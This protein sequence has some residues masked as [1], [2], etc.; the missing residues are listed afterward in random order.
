MRFLCQ[1][2]QAVPT[3]KSYGDMTDNDKKIGQK[4]PKRDAWGL[5]RVNSP[6]RLLW[7]ARF[8]S[9]IGSAMGGT[10]LIIYTAVTTNNP[11]S[12][13][14]LMLVTDFAPTLLSPLSGALSDR[15]ERKKVMI[16][17]EFLRGISL[18][19]LAFFSLTTPLL[20]LLVALNSIIGQGFDAASRS[21]VPSLVENDDLESANAALGLGTNGLDLIGPV[22]T[23]ILLPFFGVQGLLFLDAI[24]YFIAV[25][26][27]LGLPKSPGRIETEEDEK[28]SF[29][30]H[31]K[32]GLK[33]VWLNPAVRIIT[34]GFCSVVFF[35]AIDDVALVFLAKDSLHSSESEAVLLYAGAGIGLL[36]GFTL[37][38]RF[39][40]RIPFLTMLVLGYFVSSSGNILTGLAWAI[41]I[42]LG[43]QIIRGMGISM[44]DLANNTLIQ[45]FVPSH[46]LGRV[47]G[48][49]YGAV[50]LAASCSYLLGGIL[51]QF[52]NAR[53]VFIIAGGGGLVSA[54]FVALV[55]P[56]VLRRIQ[57]EAAATNRKMC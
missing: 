55:L 40:N 14:L 13:A 6:F 17:C 56:K 37:L 31:A 18:T 8:I 57:A 39:G 7:A 5:L 12:V 49:V 19:I 16:I 48:N 33:F 44:S 3:H 9:V 35:N 4:E 50:G 21:I 11:L 42:A 30:R 32:E 15:I 24:S 45:R 53:L 23:A 10:A 22:M 54:I 36:I 28:L 41:P 38:T 25:A 34:I 47:F 29:L 52:T 2:K 46:M 1:L 26:L 20:L 27:L 43:M 51:L